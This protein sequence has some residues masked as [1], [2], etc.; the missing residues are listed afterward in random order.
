LAEQVSLAL[1]ARQESKTSY[2]KSRKGDIGEIA[3]AISAFGKAEYESPVA[4]ARIDYYQSEAKRRAK[5]D[6]RKER[7]EERKHQELARNFR[8]EDFKEWEKIQSSI[9]ML[10]G[11]LNSTSDESLKDMIRDDIKGLVKRKDELAKKLNLK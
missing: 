6:E 5:E 11:Q 9:F 3:D 1:S 10:H 8:V 2:K 4:K 7:E